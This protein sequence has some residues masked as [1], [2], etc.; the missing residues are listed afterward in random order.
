MSLAREGVVDLFVFLAFNLLSDVTL[1]HQSA[2]LY[3]PSL[4]AQLHARLRHGRDRLEHSQV[5]YRQSGMHMIVTPCLSYLLLLGS[6]ECEAY[7]ILP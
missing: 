6:H 1:G 2:R 7:S 5:R 4:S 3:V